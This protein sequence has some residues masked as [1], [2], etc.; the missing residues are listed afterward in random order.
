MAAQGENVE[1]DVDS[2]IE[3]LLEVR[4]QR[5]GKQ[6]QLQESEIRALCIKS[7]EI[8]LSQ[9][10]LLELQVCRFF[11]RLLPETMYMCFSPSIIIVVVPSCSCRWQLSL[12]QCFGGAVR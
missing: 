2:V 8:F 9:P 6:V 3:K 12:K 7:R 5:P 4:G 11:L 10:I 1:L